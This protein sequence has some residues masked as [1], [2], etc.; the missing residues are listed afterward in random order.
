MALSFQAVTL[1]GT[2]P[3]SEGRLVFRDGRLFAVVSCLSE[4]HAEWAGT[5]YIEAAF[6]DLPRHQPQTFGSLAELEEWLAGSS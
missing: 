5:W 1:D 4:I 2:S 3:D 6:A